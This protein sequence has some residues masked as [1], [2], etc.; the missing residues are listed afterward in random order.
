MSQPSSDQQSLF[1]EDIQLILGLL[2]SEWIVEDMG[3][4]VAEHQLLLQL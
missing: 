2:A 4:E 1:K 3:E